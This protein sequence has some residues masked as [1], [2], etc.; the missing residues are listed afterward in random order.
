MPLY[1]YRC[2][3]CG[4]KFEAVRSVED[5][6]HALCKCGGSADFVFSIPRKMWVEPI[7]HEFVSYS[8]G[9]EPVV[10]RGRGHWRRLLKERGLVET[11]HKE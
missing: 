2:S 10:V 8:M 11:V 9:P 5:R 3:G 4:S 6:K 7:M 1:D